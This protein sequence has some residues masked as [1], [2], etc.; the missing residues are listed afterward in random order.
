MG[1]ASKNVK[2]DKGGFVVTLYH[3]FAI[4]GGCPIVASSD[5]DQSLQRHDPTAR[6]ARRVVGNRY[7]EMPRKCTL[8]WS[9]L[10]DHQR[11]QTT[12]RKAQNGDAR[13]I[14]EGLFIEP[15]KRRIG[16]KRFRWSPG[17]TGAGIR[18][19][20]AIEHQDN[21]TRRLKLPASSDVGKSETLAAMQNNDRG[22]STRACGAKQVTEQ[23][24]CA[25]RA[26][27]PGTRGRDLNQFFR[28]ARGYHGD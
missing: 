18:R 14:D 21:V 24:L 26:A 9:A 20:Q 11:R 6:T 13:R 17:P 5:E 22:L 25:T 8:K 23:R 3:C 7:S 28:S 4:R 15:P 2:H 27:E 1:R 12:H 16:V 10:R 19:P